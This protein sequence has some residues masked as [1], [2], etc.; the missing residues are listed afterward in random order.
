MAS[1]LAEHARLLHKEMK[2]L[3]QIEGNVGSSLFSVP[4]GIINQPV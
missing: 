1:L 2:T 4:L 3:N